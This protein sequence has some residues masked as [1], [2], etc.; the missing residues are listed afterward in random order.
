MRQ[1]EFGSRS[2]PW[3][4]GMLPVAPL[5]RMRPLR[6]EPRFQPWRGCVLPLHY[7]RAVKYNSLFLFKRCLDFFYHPCLF[8]IISILVHNS[9]KFFFKI[10]DDNMR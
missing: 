7:E 10:H 2:P 8:L 9:M 1:P 5:A 4:G 6:V 3:K